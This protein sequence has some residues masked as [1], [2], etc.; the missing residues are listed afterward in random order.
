MPPPSWRGWTVSRGGSHTST[1]VTPPGLILRGAGTLKLD[2]G[3]PPLGLLLNARYDRVSFDLAPGDF[4]V[5][6][7]DGV[8]EALEGIPL[9]LS[10]VLGNG[11]LP[12]SSTLQEDCDY[13]LRI[14]ASAPGPPGA[15]TWSDD[16]TVLAFRVSDNRPL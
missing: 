14:A 13:L 4:G 2:A 11:H 5:L 16:R 3:G 7:T 8:T 10:Q 12:Q 15:G 1:P 9:L 6:V